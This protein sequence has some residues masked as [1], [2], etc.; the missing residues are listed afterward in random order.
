MNN[1]YAKMVMRSI[2]NG[3]SSNNLRAARPRSGKV[4]ASP[5]SFVSRQIEET[6]DFCHSIL[7]SCEVRVC[8]QRAKFL[9]E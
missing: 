8:S 3:L 9:Q 1:R 6:L 2:I 7:K 4:I 5:P